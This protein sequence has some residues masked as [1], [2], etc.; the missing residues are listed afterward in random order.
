MRGSAQ[1]GEIAARLGYHADMGA[2]QARS[3]PARLYLVELDRLAADEAE[4]AGRLSIGERARLSTMGKA[5][6]RWRYCAG[7]A[8]LRALIGADAVAD[9]DRGTN[10]KPS[11]S[12][13][14]PFSY[15]ASGGYALIG[16]SD[17]PIGVDI[18]AIRDLALP[19][20]WAAAYPVLAAMR[21]GQERPGDTAAMRFL[22][23]WT[24]L[25]AVVKCAGGRLGASL[26]GEMRPAEPLAGAPSVAVDDVEAGPG[27]I[28][29]CASEGVAAFTLRHFD[30]S[31]LGARPV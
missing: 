10:G 26:A 24:R 28:A 7:H 18:E 4:L 1:D 2:S 30:P 15:A 17:R 9:F 27:L 31:L 12:G 22:R 25:E 3:A 11:L 5:S 16:I 21:R 6:D 8:A 19:G 13:G 23:A 29:A 20:D 14:P